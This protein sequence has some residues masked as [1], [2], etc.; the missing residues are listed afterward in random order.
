[1]LT[2]SVSRHREKYIKTVKAMN[3]AT[4]RVYNFR[5]AYFD[6]FV[7]NDYSL[8][9]MVEQIKK[10]S[11]DPYDVLNNYICYLQQNAHVSPLTLKQ[12]LVTVKNFLEYNDVDIS[13]RKFKLKVKLPK[14]IRK[15]KEALSKED[16]VNIPALDDS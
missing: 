10:G 2:T 3:K 12:R 11:Q 1:V 8:D 7:S 16:V 14:A 9:D 5:L 13:S 4:A 15:D 6:S